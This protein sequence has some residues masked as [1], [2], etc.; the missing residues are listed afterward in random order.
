MDKA[1]IIFVIII[2]TIIVIL[3]VLPMDPDPLFN[4]LTLN[5][6]MCLLFIFNYT[7]LGTADC[8]LKLVRYFLPYQLPRR[9][10][11]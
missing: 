3:W 11:V 1:F 6:Y 4:Y 9:P 7:G 5:G 8:K 2:T 10:Y